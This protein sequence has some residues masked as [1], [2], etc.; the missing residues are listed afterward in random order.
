[1]DGQRRWGLGSGAWGGSPRGRAGRVTGALAVAARSSGPRYAPGRRSVEP[2]PADAGLDGIPSWPAVK[3]LDAGTGHNHRHPQISFWNCSDPALLPGDFVGRTS[4]LATQRHR[5]DSLALD[6]RPCVTSNRRGSANPKFPGGPRSCAER[7]GR[8]RERFP[9]GG[10][11]GGGRRTS[12][13]RGYMHPQRVRPTRSRPRASNVMH[14]HPVGC[15]K[16]G[17]RAHEAELGR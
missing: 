6:R 11:P 2:P 1:V 10:P 15:A 5:Q 17:R 3:E 12:R 9:A 14:V 16:A 7:P 13:V 8:H 4:G